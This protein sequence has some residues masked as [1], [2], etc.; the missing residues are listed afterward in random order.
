MTDGIKNS[1]PVSNQVKIP[2]ELV[3]FLRQET[4]SLLIKGHTGTGKT[5]L[6][7]SILKELNINKNCLYISTR[8]SPANLFQYYPWIK[9]FFHQLKKT[10]P[11]EA[12][13]NEINHTIFVDGRL[14]EPT[15]LFERITNELMDM[16]APTIIIDTWDAKIDFL[17]CL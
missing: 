17:Y 9:K 5:T 10:E 3:Q 1:R 13:E 6:A 8:V 2:K 7:L 4:Y 12:Y 14:D 16:Y 11:A 15:S